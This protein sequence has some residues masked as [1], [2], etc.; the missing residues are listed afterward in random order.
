MEYGT[1]QRF[2]V[3]SS[4]VQNRQKLL[5]VKIFERLSSRHEGWRHGVGIETARVH[6]AAGCRILG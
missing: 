2:L 6:R 3:Y 1:Y 4:S 5:L